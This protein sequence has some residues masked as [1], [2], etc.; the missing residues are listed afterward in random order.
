MPCALGVQRFDIWQVRTRL[1]SVETEPIETMEGPHVSCVAPL[2]GKLSILWHPRHTAAVAHQVM[3]VDIPYYTICACGLCVL[4]YVSVSVGARGSVHLC[5][6]TPHLSWV[7]SFCSACC[8]CT[9]PSLL[10]RPTSSQDLDIV[11]DTV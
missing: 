1:L 2:L 3:C 11:S 4:R 10:H 9:M 5:A 7:F 6:G 8:C